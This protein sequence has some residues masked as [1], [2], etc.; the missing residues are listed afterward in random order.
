[1]AARFKLKVTGPH[2]EAELTLTIGEGEKHFFGR[3]PEGI[4][5]P[6]SSISREHGYFI[7]EDHLLFVVDNKSRNGIFVNGQRVAKATCEV[8]QVISVPPF[9]M[10]VLSIDLDATNID[11]Q[12]DKIELLLADTKPRVESS[13]LLKPSKSF[14]EGE[15]LKVLKSTAPKVIAPEPE[16][17]KSQP[18][19]V[20]DLDEVRYPIRFYRDLFEL[21]ILKPKFFFEGQHFRGELVYSLLWLLGLSGVSA[22]FNLLTILFWGEKFFDLTL[23]ME[24]AYFAVQWL[25]GVL[26]P[27]GF[28]AMVL[29][30]K[31]FLGVRGRFHHFLRFFVFASILATLARLLSIVPFGLGFITGP[32]LLLWIFFGLNQVF[33]IREKIKAAAIALLFGALLVTIAIRSQRSYPLAIFGINALLFSKSLNLEEKVDLSAKLKSDPQMKRVMELA[34]KLQTGIYG[35]FE[36]GDRYSYEV[37]LK[38]PGFARTGMMNIEVVASSGSASSLMVDGDFGDLKKRFQKDILHNDQLIKPQFYF[39]RALSA[40]DVPQIFEL[41][42]NKKIYSERMLQNFSLIALSESQ[43]FNAV[44]L[45]KPVGYADISGLEFDQFQSFDRRYHN[46]ESGTGPTGLRS[47]AISKDSALPLFMMGLESDLK[48]GFRYRLVTIKKNQGSR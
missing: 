47:L 42:I 43:E 40:M 21:M 44:S 46:L 28:A 20:F 27:M 26:W 8:D 36:V 34:E 30:L 6:D 23:P 24:F 29:G 25:W 15:D 9:D 38:G 33:K 4:I 22:S 18:G 14:V 1:M 31:Q 35:K 13:D 19:P 12:E 16:P 45:P 48:L 11:V 3:T 2:T 10:K 39:D 41:F 7:F 32:I 37:R 5:L 17:P